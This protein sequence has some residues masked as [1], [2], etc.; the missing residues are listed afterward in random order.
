MIRW[1]IAAPLVALALSSTANAVTDWRTCPPR[2]DAKGYNL[3]VLFHDINWDRT[4]E[5]DK[6]SRVVDKF[7]ANARWLDHFYE[8]GNDQGT[9]NFVKC[10]RLKVSS[11]PRDPDYIW[12]GDDHPELR[13]GS[14]SAVATPKQSP[15]PQAEEKPEAKCSARDIEGN[16]KRGDGASI[17]LNGMNLKDGGRALMFNNP[18]GWPAG[19]FKFS[20]IKQ[21]SGCEFQA[22]CQTVHRNSAG[23]GYNISKESCTL[24]LDKKAGTLKAPGSHGSYTR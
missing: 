1:Y 16:W 13:Q 20:G 5:P 9:A 14:N 21:K 3:I 10:D 23:G 8:E 7:C 18:N 12:C 22:T 4:D 17:V 15:V 24:V 11:F 6:K 2:R 19:A